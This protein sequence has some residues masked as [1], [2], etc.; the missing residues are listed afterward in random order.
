MLAATRFGS[1]PQPS[2]LRSLSDMSTDELKKV[3]AGSLLLMK[4]KTW[5]FVPLSRAVV[6]KP[7]QPWRVHDS[8]QRWWH[9]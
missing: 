1:S 8:R 9:R 5:K 7:D 2:V 4:D 6:I 3:L